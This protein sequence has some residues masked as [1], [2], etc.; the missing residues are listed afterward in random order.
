MI[1][2]YMFFSLFVLKNILLDGFILANFRIY[3]LLLL[4]QE[5]LEIFF[6]AFD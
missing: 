6:E 1:L 2:L 3:Y 5:L 4:V